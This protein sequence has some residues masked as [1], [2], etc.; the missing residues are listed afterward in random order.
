MK[1][2]AFVVALA[3]CG[4]GSGVDGDKQIT[5]LNDDEIHDLC[6]YI[7]DVYGASRTIDCG[8]AMITVGGLDPDVWVATTRAVQARNPPGGATV[9]DKEACENAIANVSDSQLCSGDGVIPSVC[10]PLLT[11]EC[12]GN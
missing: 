7:V 4:S 5:A 12:G 1:R 9:S 2:W 3:A 10:D 6:D 8:T 11:E